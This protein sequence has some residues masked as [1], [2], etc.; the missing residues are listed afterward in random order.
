MPETGIVVRRAN[1]EI[2]KLNTR[3]S[4]LRGKVEKQAGKIQ[5]VAVAVA[6]AYMFGNFQ[7]TAISESRSLPTIGHMDPALTWGA[8]LYF[9][10]PMIGGQAG[11]VA[12]SAGLGILCAYAYS[13]GATPSREPEAPTTTP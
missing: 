2:E 10:G 12:E 3:L 11:M 5:T 6:G 9:A 7:R 1:E 13:R 4:G 8:G